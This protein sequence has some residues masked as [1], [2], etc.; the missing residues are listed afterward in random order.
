MPTMVSNSLPTA[1]GRVQPSEALR[2]HLLERVFFMHTV[3]L[4]IMMSPAFE[5]EACLD[6]TRWKHVPPGKVGTMARLKTERE[7]GG[8]EQRDA[9]VAPA[10]VATPPTGPAPTATPPP[11]PPEPTADTAPEPAAGTAPIPTPAP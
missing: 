10:P 7:K 1:G 2:Q 9:A 11:P 4:G 3:Y 5:N 8:Q 6:E